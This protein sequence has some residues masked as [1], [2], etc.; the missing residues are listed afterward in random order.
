MS[1]GRKQPVGHQIV[2][3]VAH[4]AILQQRLWN[5]QEKGNTRHSDIAYKRTTS[6]QIHEVK[7]ISS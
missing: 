5:P 6:T 7:Y 2:I 3:T 4:Q 1:Q